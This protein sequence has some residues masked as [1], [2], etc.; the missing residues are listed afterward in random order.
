MQT[1][2]TVRYYL[3]TSRMFIIKKKK[4]RKRK[5]KI[6]FVKDVKKWE[7]LCTVGGNVKWNNCHGW[8]CVCICID[9]SKN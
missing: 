9:S 8:H 6:Y 5:K 3:T 4:K 1:E 7:H 2:M